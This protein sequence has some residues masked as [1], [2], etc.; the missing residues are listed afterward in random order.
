[1]WTLFVV[2]LLLQHLITNPECDKPYSDDNFWV[3]GHV[4]SSFNLDVLESVYIVTRDPVLCRQ[5]E[6]VLSSGLSK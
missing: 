1:M 6:P 5:K 3:I 2:V 4:R